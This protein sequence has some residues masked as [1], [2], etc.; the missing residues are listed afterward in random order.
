[1]VRVDI[2]KKSGI[3]IE[4]IEVVIEVEAVIGVGMQVQE[5]LITAS[6][7][8]RTVDHHHSVVHYD[9][10]GILIVIV[11]LT[12]VVLM[13]LVMEMERVEVTA[14]VEGTVQVA[15]VYLMLDEMDL[16]MMI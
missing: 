4:G 9:H 13:V 7:M 6:P 16:C 14:R 12:I 15:D 10:H 8:I 1:M 3:M 2:L 11:I 5:L